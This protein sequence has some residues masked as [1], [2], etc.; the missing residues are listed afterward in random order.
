MSFEIIGIFHK[1]RDPHSGTPFD[2]H[3]HSAVRQ[4]QKLQNIGHDAH[5]KDA[6]CIRFIDARINLAGQQNFLVVL[7]HRFQRLHRLFASNEKRDNHVRKHND[8][9]Q[10][11]Y[12]M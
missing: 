7:H 10:W 3:F 2:Q 6:V 5:A 4:F 11:Q 12:G 1:V 9:A 8:V